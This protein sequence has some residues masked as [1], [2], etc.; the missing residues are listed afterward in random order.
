MM[1]SWLS[2]IGQIAG[3]FRALS[4]WWSRRQLIEAGKR[5]AEGEYNAEQLDKIR[6]ANSARINGDRVRSDQYRD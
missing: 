4:E 5:E 6:R 1:S 3:I 2:A